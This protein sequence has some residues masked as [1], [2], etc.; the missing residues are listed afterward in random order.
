MEI[1]EFLLARIAADEALLA[2]QEWEDCDNDAHWTNPRLRRECEAKRLLIE[3]ITHMADAEDR[4]G[5]YADEFLSFLA[6][7]YADHPDFDPE[8]AA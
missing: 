2:A 5:G 8:W 1:S 6:L 3:R 4:M 7:P